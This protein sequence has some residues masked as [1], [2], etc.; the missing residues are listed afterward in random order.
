M[1]Y[2]SLLLEAQRMNIEVFEKS[3]GGNIQGLYNDG[4]VWINKKIS[5][6]HDKY[7]VLAE[8]IGHHVT[9]SGDI[10][11]QSN[12]VNKKQELRARY[13]AY[14]KLVPLKAIITAHKA[15]IRNR[16]ELA[17]HLGVSERFLD[18]AISRYKEKYG[19][20]ATVDK[21]TIC[22]EPLGVIELFDL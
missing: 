21:Y 1:T 20:A 17:E 22:F 2:E 16:Y 15:G 19:A 13:W 4:V 7:C 9:T 18:S 8:E 6:A 10:L 12:I 11:D 14:E 5:T 3:I